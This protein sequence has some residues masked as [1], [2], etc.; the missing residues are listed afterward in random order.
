MSFVDNGNP[1]S[2]IHPPV[3]HGGDSSAGGEPIKLTLT[4]S[5]RAVQRM[6]HLLHRANI[7]SGSAWSRPTLARH[8][9][10]VMSVAVRHI[11]I[12]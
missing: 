7:I 8:A 4:G 9:G 2:P 12:D 6:I 1:D 10:E 3:D 5:R 11:S